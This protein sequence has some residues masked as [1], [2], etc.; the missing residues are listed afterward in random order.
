VEKRGEFAFLHGNPA[1]KT[2]IFCAKNFSAGNFQEKL[3]F[4]AAADTQFCG[5]WALKFLYR[6]A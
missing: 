6:G 3:P 2:A 5:G 1:Q 4:F